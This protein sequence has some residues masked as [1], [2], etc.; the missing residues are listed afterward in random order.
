MTG[1]LEDVV[2]LD[3]S[4]VL[5]GPWCTQLLADMGAEVIKLERPGSGDET[6]GWG[7][8]YLGED[9]DRQSAYFLCANRGKQAL[10]VDFTTEAGRRIVE[11]LVRQVDVV[12]ENF[13]VGALARYGLDYAA[14]KKINPRLIYCSITGFG[15]T[16]P[17]AGRAGYDFILQGMGGLMSVTGPPD[18]EPGGGPYR[19]GVALT[20]ILTG[21]YASNGILAALHARERTGVGQHI[22]LALLDVQVATLANQALAYLATGQSPGRTGNAHP[23]IVPYQTFQ[24]ADAPINIAVGNDSQFRRLCETLGVDELAADPRF[25]ANS[26]RAAHKSELTQRLQAVFST[27]PVAEWTAMLEAKGVP[28][29]PINTLEQVFADPQVQH[30]GMRIDLPHPTLGTAPGVACPLN[31]SDAPSGHP[32]APPLIGQHTDEIL[33]G[34]LGMTPEAIAGMKARGEIG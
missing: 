10:A 33:S 31:F 30:R 14:L 19:V 24:A 16:G 1:L 25:T 29:G 28:A 9:G 4:R 3:L 34:R 20:D 22:D 17:Y 8:P 7:P 2:V 18:G 6:R 13:K 12:V 23:T 27:R 15:Q 32:N 5:A 26:A 11:D 21:L